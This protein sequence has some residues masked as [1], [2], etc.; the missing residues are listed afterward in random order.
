M[1]INLPELIWYGNT[2][3][4]I[5]LPEEWQVEYLPMNGADKPPMTVEQME[6]AINNPIG[7]STIKDLAK[8][9]NRAVILFD[10][11]TRPTR[12]YEIAPIVIE[13]LKAGGISEDAITFVCAP[14]T[15]G[16][17]TM[18]EFRKKLGPELVKKFRVFNHNIYENCVDIGTTS[19]GTKMMINREVAEA[20]LR[21]AIG[22]VTAHPQVGFCGGGKIILPGIAHVDSISHYHLEVAPM[23]PETMGLGNFDHNILRADIADAIELA[24]LEFMVNVIVN[25]RGATTDIFAGDFVDAH[26]EAVKTAMDHYA[27]DP[28]PAGKDLVISNAFVKANEMTIAAGLGMATLKNYSG[29]VVAIANS[30]EGQVVHYLLGRYG[31]DYGGRQ[32]P[33]VTVPDQVNLIIQAPYR[34]KTFGDWY[35]NPEVITWTECWDETLALLKE[36]FGAG[37]EVGVIP[38]ATMQYY[39]RPATPAV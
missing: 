28:K 36:S 4:E 12:T 23:A 38:N 14:G 29:T 17:L 22:A 26:N 2:T 10:D 27:S 21:I 3:L 1:R 34:D 32:Y 5:D 15:H 13:E 37:A 6:A 30:P 11:M 24:G 31:R 19:R 35:S 8:G 20:D 18:N 39:R 33:I 9:K 16:A 25:G 7:A